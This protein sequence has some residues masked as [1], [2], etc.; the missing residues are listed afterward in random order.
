MANFGDMKSWVAKRLQDPS[1]TAV[2]YAD[3]GD[4]INQA[5]RY[6][7]DTRFEFNEITDSTTLTQGSPNIPIPSDWLVP[8]IDSCFVIEYSGIRY[9]LKKVSEQMYN[10]MY[11]SN[12]I[13]QPFC[14]AKLASG[15]Y[16]CYPKPDRDYDLLRFYLRN[17]DDLVNDSDTNDFTIKADSLIKYTAAAYGSRDFRQD[18]NMYN[19]F[20]AQAKMEKEN[21]LETTRKANATGSLTISSMLM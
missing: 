9:P 14:F 18:N 19:A 12:G 6:W 11:L 1:G 15:G 2:S 16:Q 20:W 7:K 21:L 3:I 13:G 17:Y 8:S 10:N 5:I 4:M